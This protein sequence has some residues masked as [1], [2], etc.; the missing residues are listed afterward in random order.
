MPY[1]ALMR[2]HLTIKETI[3]ALKTIRSALCVY[4]AP[5]GRT[6]DCKFGVQLEPGRPY[7]VLP[8]GEVGCGCPELY[9]AIYYLE[10]QTG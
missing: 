8:R 7:P 10:K 6:C 4:H 1:N 5:Y 3:D 9:Q 2:Q